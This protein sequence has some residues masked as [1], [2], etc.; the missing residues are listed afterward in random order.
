LDVDFSRSGL[1]CNA[2]SVDLEIVGSKVEGPNYDE[3][4][5]IGDVF[6]NEDS[7]DFFTHSWSGESSE[8][9]DTRRESH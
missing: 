4:C 8:G 6:P 9:I 1:S 7:P 2:G 3:S 5:Y